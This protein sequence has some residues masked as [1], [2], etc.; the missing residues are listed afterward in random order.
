MRITLFILL[1]C[2]PIITNAQSIKKSAPPN[3]LYSSGECFGEKSSCYYFLNSD[4]SFIYLSNDYGIVDK[5]GIGIWFWNKN[6]KEDGDSVISF[7]FR[8][9][10]SNILVNS[11]IEYISETKYSYDSIYISGKILSPDGTPKSF[12]PVNFKNTKLATGTNKEGEFKTVL[13]HSVKITAIEPWGYIPPAVYPVTL[14]LNPNNN[15]HNFEII[16]APFDS[17]S[18]LTVESGET[19]SL[20][21]TLKRPMLPGFGINFI[22]EEST[23]MKKI[24]QEAILNQPDAANALRYLLNK[25]K[26]AENKALSHK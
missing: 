10:E 18:V 25:I 21:W 19:I 5:I 11:K 15:V 7:L 17:L 12:L 8:D 14:N 26:V 23:I 13:H 1:F 4:S 24:I 6:R 3:G 22:S 2:Y 9:I 20:K 16:M